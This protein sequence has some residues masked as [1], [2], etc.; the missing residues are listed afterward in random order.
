MPELPEV[1][2]TARSLRPRLVGRR[3][4]CVGGVD[5]PRMLP[6]T[7]QDELR[8]VLTGLAV[9][10]VDRRGKYLLI[11]FEHD[12]WLAIHRKMSGNLLLRPAETAAEP[13]T[14]L[15]I[16]LDDGRLLRFVDARKF[17]RVYLFGSRGELDAFIAARLGPEP[18]TDL[19]AASLTTLLRGR[20]GRIKS[21]LLD[22]AFL[23]GVGNL[24][25]DE[26]LWEARVHPL[27]AAD[28]LSSREIARLAL[29]IQHVL[30]LGIERRGT[31]FSTYRDADDSRGENQDHLSVYGREGQPCPRCGTRI[32]RIVIGMRSAYF[33]PHCQRATVRRP[34]TS[35]TASR[36]G[37]A[38]P[39]LA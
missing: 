10:T 26:A 5:W 13:H 30:M 24:Y 22:Q 29:A 32:R 28:S 7:A 12:R 2:S 19:S 9:S 16:G 34:A 17:G 14:H 35:G 20:R 6:N 18:L 3:V 39:G 23:A 21:L 15:E 31:S 4:R 11:G 25:A 27:R 33:C 37:T 36:S 8:A 1:E 38:R